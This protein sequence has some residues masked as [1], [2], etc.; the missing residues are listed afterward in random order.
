MF[1]PNSPV[2]ISLYNVNRYVALFAGTVDAAKKDPFCPCSSEPTVSQCSFLHAYFNGKYAYPIVKFKCKHDLFM[3]D[4]YVSTFFLS[5]KPLE[6]GN[7]SYA[8]VVLCG[9][10]CICNYELFSIN[11]TF[12]K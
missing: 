1:L 7:F 3:S 12:S 11:E 4:L 6:F 10:Y 5:Y 8:V 9:V 2:D